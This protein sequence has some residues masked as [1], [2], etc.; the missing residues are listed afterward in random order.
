MFNNGCEDSSI[1][2]NSS[3]FSGFI[4]SKQ[5]HDLVAVY[6]QTMLN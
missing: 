1:I 3:K 4:K 2:V 5:V 6:Q